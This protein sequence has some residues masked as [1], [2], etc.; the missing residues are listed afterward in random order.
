MKPT[1][2]AQFCFN[3]ASDY[4]SRATDPAKHFS[5]LTFAVKKTAEGLS[6]MSIGLRATY[7]LLEEVK[8]ML[9]RQNASPSRRP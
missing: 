8:E 2:M 6:A 3:M 7:M 4:A 9:Q 1:E 5:D